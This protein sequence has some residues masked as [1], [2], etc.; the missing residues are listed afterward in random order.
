MFSGG[1]M[2]IITCKVTEEEKEVIDRLA[3]AN[4]SEYMRRCLLTGLGARVGNLN[5]VNE[6]ISEVNRRLD[7]LFDQVSEI[8]MGVFSAELKGLVRQL[9][10]LKL[11]PP[12]QMMLHESLAIET[13]LLLRSMSAPAKVKTAWG[14][15]ERNGYKIWEG[16]D[17]GIE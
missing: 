6:Q 17:G 2:P 7:N 12:G 16:K 5:Q 1:V 10:Q 3:G 13:V 8:D 11:P 14:E 9:S 15:I 4:R